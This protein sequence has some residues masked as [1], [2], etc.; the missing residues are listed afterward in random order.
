ML[1]VLNIISRNSN[2]AMCQTQIVID[3]LKD[4]YPDLTIH[5]EKIITKGD[6]ILDTSLNLIGGKGLFTQE[7]EQRLKNK[8]S[9]LA[10]HSAK[11]LP[12]NLSD[13]FTISAYLQREDPSDCFVSNNF[14]SI[15]QMPDD[16]VIGTSSIRRSSL[17]KKYFPN[18]KIK[19]LRGNVIT[20]LQKLDQGLYDGIILASAGLYR[21]GLFHR[22][23]QK[24]PIDVFIPSIGQGALA[25]ETLFIRNYIHE[26]LIPLNHKNTFIEVE[27]ER[28]IGKL[29]NAGCSSPIS[30]YAK[31]TDNN[32][33]L[34]AA[35]L[36]PNTE[37]M[38][39][40]DQEVNLKYKSEL[41]NNCIDQ[42]NRQ[43]AQ[44]ILKR[45]I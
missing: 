41:V 13:E 36:D 10:V 4:I 37:L 38:C 9:D 45:Y 5:I 11:D 24:L 27:T 43:G 34:I 31:I 23:K 2:L 26:F 28:M 39:K 21:L 3:K 14:L 30:A 19:M 32:I 40:F 17:L 8:T 12:S 1:N 18:L 7:L 35:V 29:L 42:L 22:I 15:E 16:S 44:A 33:R 25:I 20:R 6:I